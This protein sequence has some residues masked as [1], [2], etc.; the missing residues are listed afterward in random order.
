VLLVVIEHGAVVTILEVEF[1][2]LGVVVAIGFGKG[3]F[4][5]WSLSCILARHCII[6]KYSG[7]HN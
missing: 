7:S 2:G 5:G 6:F 4:I 3:K 1:D